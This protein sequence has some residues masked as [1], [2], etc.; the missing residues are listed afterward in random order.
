M[1]KR[2]IVSKKYDVRMCRP[3]ALIQKRRSIIA[4]DKTIIAVLSSNVVR[5]YTLL[6]YRV[7]SAIRLAQSRV[8]VPQIYA[9]CVLGDIN[10]VVSGRWI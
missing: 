6:V 5:G 2:R 9:R 1:W 3:T 8:S 10:Q 4:S 7:F